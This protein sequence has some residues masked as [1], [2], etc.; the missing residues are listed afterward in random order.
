MHTSHW[1]E[2]AERDWL[3]RFA[4]T[5]AGRFISRGTPPDAAAEHAHA[6]ADASYP[7]RTAAAPEEEADQ[8]FQSLPRA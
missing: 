7:A 1:P 6:Q 4:T 2:I 8:V 3:A 5:L